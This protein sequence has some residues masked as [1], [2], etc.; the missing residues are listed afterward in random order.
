MLIYS[1]II[2]LC[3]GIICS[4]VPI[5]L[6]LFKQIAKNRSY[7]RMVRYFRTLSGT[8]QDEVEHEKKSVS[9]R[10]M[11]KIPKPVITGLRSLLDRHGKSESDP[12]PS[13]NE[14]YDTLDSAED[15]YHMQLRK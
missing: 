9:Y 14:K 4:S 10:I 1:S 6:V 5:L 15:D 12:G 7:I 8:A 2:E 11:H 13:D 3:V